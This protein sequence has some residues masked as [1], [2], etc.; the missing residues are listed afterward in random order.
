MIETILLIKALSTYIL[1]LVP[2][3][4]VTILPS[5]STVYA[6]SLLTINCSVELDTAVDS[7]FTVVTIWRKNGVEF[8]TLARRTVQETVLIKNSLY[9][10]Q[11]V[12]DP[13]QLDTDDGQYSCEI[14]VN[15]DVE[16]VMETSVL[17]STVSLSAA[18]NHM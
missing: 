17:S 7:P 13:V 8:T 12:F 5:I 3:P 10:A 15:P 4:T 6:G 11:V 14:I 18:G 9:R 1:L 16:F 2:P